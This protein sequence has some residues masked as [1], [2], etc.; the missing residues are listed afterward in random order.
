MWLLPPRPLA[1]NL[2]ATC[3]EAIGE[4]CRP[5]LWA[6]SIIALLIST[7]TGFRSLA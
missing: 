7:A 4:G 3:N 1:I 6:S 5:W 2:K